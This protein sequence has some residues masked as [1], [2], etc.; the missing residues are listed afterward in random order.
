MSN[1]VNSESCGRTTGAKVLLA[2]DGIFQA[3][4]AIELAAAFMMPETRTVASSPRERRLMMAPGRV[5]ASGYGLAA[6]GTF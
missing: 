5:G 3:I 1:A 6:V 2:A 4:G